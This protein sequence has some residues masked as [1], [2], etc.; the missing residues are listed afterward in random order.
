MLTGNKPVH[1][2][3]IYPQTPWGFSVYFVKWCQ[4]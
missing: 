1:R 2:S 4:V 3:H